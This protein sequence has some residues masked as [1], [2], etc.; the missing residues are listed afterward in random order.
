MGAGRGGE[1]GRC[2]S[3]SGKGGGRVECALIRGWAL[4][5]FF[6]L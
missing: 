2:L 1:G 3:L 6:C 4:I 5:N